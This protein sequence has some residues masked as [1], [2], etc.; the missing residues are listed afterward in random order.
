MTQSA[1]NIFR[2]D[3]KTSVIT[4]GGSGIGRAIALKFA[5]QGGK[6]HILDL[7]AKDAEATCQ[8]IT[9]AGGTARGHCC[10]VTDQKQV[11]AKFE[12]IAK[13][14]PISILAYN[15]GISHIGAVESTRRTISI[16]AGFI[17]GVDYLLDGGFTNLRG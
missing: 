16:E 8:Q 15:A 6:I 1:G 12:E 10:D 3:G 2:F 4:G 5:A 14:G 11:I 7:S 13:E 17:T 9:A